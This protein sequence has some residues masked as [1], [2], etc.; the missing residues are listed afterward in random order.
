MSETPKISV[1]GTPINKKDPNKI[2]E[3]HQQLR[4]YS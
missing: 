1:P 3:W 4:A 2:P